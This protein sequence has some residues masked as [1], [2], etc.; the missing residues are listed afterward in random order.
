MSIDASDGTS[1]VVLFPPRPLADFAIHYCGTAFHVHKIFL[2]HHSAYFR[3]YF[4]ALS[5][6]DNHN[7]SKQNILRCPKLALPSQKSL[8]P[9]SYVRMARILKLCPAKRSHTCS[10]PRLRCDDGTVR[11]SAAGADGV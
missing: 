8:R 10:L 1:P 9:D 6:D 3:A 4:E 11:F 7:H 2:F 5:T